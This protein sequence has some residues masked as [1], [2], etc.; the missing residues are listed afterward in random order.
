M[1]RTNTMLAVV[2]C[3]CF[4]WL[5]TKSICIA[6]E[7][8][9]GREVYQ[10]G[11]GRVDI[12]PKYPIRLNGFG[13]RREES[14]GIGEP[15]WAK[16]L[17]IQKGDAAPILIIAIDSLGIRLPMVDEVADR[18]HKEFQIPR[19]NIAITFSHSHCTP[20][21][22]GASDTIF[23]TP[24][25]P[26]HQKHIDTYSAEL[27]E[28]LTECGR[29]AL[30]SKFAATLEFGIGNVGFAANRRTPGGPVDHD[31]PVLVARDEKNEIRAI[32]TSYAC[33]CVTLSYNKVNGDWAGY[34]Q[35]WIERK[36]PGAVGLV[37]IGCGSDSNP[38]SGVTGDKQE[39]ASNQGAAIADEVERVVKSGL[40][41][42]S[43]P[44]SAVYKTIDLPLE[45]PPSRE[46]L[47]EM[48]KAKGPAGFNAE[49]QLAKLAR[50]EALPTKLDY[51]IQTF[52][53][54]DSLAI[55]FLAGEVC[56]DFSLRLKQELDGSR[57]WTNG[58]SNDFCAYIP[59]ER[60]LK[61]GGYGGGA[62]VVYFAL[63]NVLKPGLEQKIVDEVKRQVPAAFVPPPGTQGVP[64]KSPEESR[65]A[66][67]V[68]P[69]FEVELVAAEPLVDDPVAIDFGPDRRLWVAEMANYAFEPQAEFKQTGRV[70]F[71]TDSNSDG[72]YDQATLFLEG[73]RFP[74]DVKVWRDGV[75][76]CD[77]PDILF[78][79]D[80]DNDGKADIVEKKYTGF[81]THN[82]HARVNSLRWGLDNWLH[83]SGG[84]FGGVIQND[85]G[86]TINLGARD[87]RISPDSGKLE[88]ATGN[89]QQGR[90]RDDF[91]NWY[92]CD[93]GTLIRHYPIV[94]EYTRRNPYVATPP[95]QVF[96]HLDADPGKLF[97]AGEL[98]T[99]KL[100]GPP[101]RPT[102]ACGLEIYRDRLLGD[103]FYGNS[104]TCEP[105]NQL[106]HRIVV[107]KQGIVATGKRADEEQDR[108][109]LTST[110]KW[111][112]PV[113]ARTG[114][115]GALWIVDMYRYVIEHP[116]WIPDETKADLNVFAGQGLGRIYR[117]VPKGK[118]LR[119][120][121]DLAKASPFDL[122][123][124]LESSNGVVRDLAHQ[125]LYWHNDWTAADRLHQIAQESSIPAARAHALSLL[126]TFNK[127]E[128][129]DITTNLTSETEP[130][131]IV[132][133][134]RWSETLKESPALLQR[135]SAMSKHSSQSVRFQAWLSRA[136]FTNSSSISEIV[137]RLKDPQLEGYE[138]W[139][140]L[141][142]IS[143]E[144]ASVWSDYLREHPE[145]L[146]QVALVRDFALPSC[147]GLSD[148][149]SIFAW[150]NFGLRGEPGEMSLQNQYVLAS[151][152][153]VLDSS[154][155]QNVELPD[156]VARR[157]ELELGSAID[158]SA[159]KEL[160]EENR[161][162]ALQLVGI[163]ASLIDLPEKSFE[164]I[165]RLIDASQ[166]IA[167]QTEATGIILRSHK[168][169]PIGQLLGKL[170]GLT[171][172]IQKM[173]IDV[174]LRNMQSAE[175]LLELIAEGKVPRSV[176]SSQQRQTLL[177]SED[178]SLRKKA[179]GALGGAVDANRT[180]LIEK[181]KVALE[182]NGNAAMG[183]AIF[184]KSCATCHRIGTIGT[185][186]G[187]DLAA[188]DNRTPSSLLISI[189]DPSR[190]IDYKY[191]H[192]IAET[193]S[194]QNEAGIIIEESGASITLARQDGTKVQLLRSE[195]DILRNSGKSL[196]PEG[197]EE[198]V[199]IENVRDLIAF[200]M[201]LSGSAKKVEG[202]EP[203]LTL[204]KEEGG[205]LELSAKT[206]EIYGAQ[207]TFEQA[208][209]NIGL[210]HSQGDHLIWQSRIAVEGDY[211]VI[212]EYACADGAAGNQ[213]AFSIGDQSVV[214]VVKGTGGWDQYREVDLGKLHLGVGDHVAILLPTATVQG[215]LMDLRRIKLVPISSKSE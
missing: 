1:S 17:A 169:E 21:V 112:R 193:K 159:N 51:A 37:S 99:F 207:I 173:A 88:P 90:S 127:L 174:Q 158:A 209:A 168:H 166:P 98:V 146:E 149:Q 12:S 38:N 141:S 48:V 3:C 13:F 205:E 50:G 130:E 24:I 52:S 201:T 160:P 111:F 171:P 84:L 185:A 93:N 65:R 161:I 95:T 35:N 165:D 63:P 32:Y 101:G 179:E 153:R 136:N 133:S 213:F 105:V 131:L 108:E 82:P 143:S 183:R 34:A 4:H 29:Q 64:A 100:S 73:L 5:L 57:L 167:I 28:M 172:V 196:M 71:L 59:S 92:G 41:P 75:L 30:K 102:S 44:I 56:V 91:D 97:P 9:S 25:P 60:L 204:Q 47:E 175:R 55:L 138:A 122:A 116:R 129:A 186:L 120:W 27:V 85:R 128:E 114:P 139:S 164:L 107:G 110:D 180:K 178:E 81:T 53:F 206:A 147:I 117:I 115:D 200:L 66:I 188:I 109:F 121:P 69:R 125:L 31:L 22:N 148:E 190:D 7:S 96:A 20:K 198:S 78:A 135:L 177:T 77:A 40:R 94:D 2:F 144:N 132:Q 199:T 54:G 113:Q 155:W 203:K 49:F 86:E 134:L 15:I 156:Q 170:D 70:K 163:V 45:D 192:F 72:Q 58:Y 152:A 191:S 89:T 14:E 211:R 214:G 26:D 46:K 195:I 42:I 87:F 162:R 67:N 182:G 124:E 103:E 43:G 33:H 79:K 126:A 194:G 210:W 61:E 187:P 123:N 176:L 83:G 154:R 150:L 215:A 140:I 19:E 208:F 18:L 157:L 104:F 62:E 119:V 74:T 181:Y 76:I 197:I 11:V 212:M 39:I 16:G 23:S 10:V 80:T 68:D 8:E 145:L 184:A 6:E 202:N 142:G 118:K 137:E 36:Y 151:I 189:L 106:V